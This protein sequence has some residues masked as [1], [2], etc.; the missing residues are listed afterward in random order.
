M[1]VHM[2]QTTISFYFVNT[3][4]WNINPGM[5]QWRR[6]GFFIPPHTLWTPTP[7][8]LPLQLHS[9]PYC[10]PTTLP[11]PLHSHCTPNTH[12]THTPTALPNSLHSH[13]HCSPTPTALPHLLH[14][15]THYTPH[16]QIFPKPQHFLNCVGY[17]RRFLFAS[18]TSF[19]PVAASIPRCSMLL[20][21][22]SLRS[23]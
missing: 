1:E 21:N 8:E 2:E 10:T 14:S 13:T 19:L 18:E 6:L 23:K 12:C 3:K 11:H 5:E 20:P 4:S 16:T 15:H 22:S 9:H 7:T 17:S